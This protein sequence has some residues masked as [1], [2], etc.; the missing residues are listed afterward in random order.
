MT[1][2]WDVA[3]LH[4]RRNIPWDSS[5]KGFNMTKDVPVSVILSVSEMSKNIDFLLTLRHAKTNPKTRYYSN[6]NAAQRGREM[7]VIGNK[8]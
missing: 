5:P 4:Q 7:P 1:K 3:M 8:N 2:G 6:E